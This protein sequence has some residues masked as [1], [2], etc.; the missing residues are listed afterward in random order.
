MANDKKDDV[1]IE[2]IYGHLCRISKEDFISEFKITEQ[3]LTDEV[4]NRVKSLKSK[5]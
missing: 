3:G 4:I 5:G 2:K 1:D